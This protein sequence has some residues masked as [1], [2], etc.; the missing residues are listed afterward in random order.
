VRIQK[1]DEIG[2]VLRMAL[3]SDEPFLIEVMTD[4]AAHPPISAFAGT[5]DPL[6]TMEST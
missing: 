2:P 4:P 5:L 1:P 3:A 6:T